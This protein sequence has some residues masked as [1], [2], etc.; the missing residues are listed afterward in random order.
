V[1][2]AG[3]RDPPDASLISNGPAS[4]IC[5]T[6][7]QNNAACSYV[8]GTDDLVAL[9]GTDPVCSSGIWLDGPGGPP[10]CVE[11]NED[12]DCPDGGTCEADNTCL[13]AATGEQQ[14]LCMYVSMSA[15]QLIDQLPFPG[16]PFR[17]QSN[18]KK[19]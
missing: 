14:G 18:A 19:R 2:N 15:C 13:A 6:P 11:C 17:S 7:A 8:C 5:V 3:C 16:P 9:A 12:D 4:Y 1:F 10:Q